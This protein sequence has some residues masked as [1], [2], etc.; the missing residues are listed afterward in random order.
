ME[1]SH[2]PTT[3]PYE[4]FISMEYELRKHLSEQVSNF[5]DVQQALIRNEDV[6]FLWSISPVVIGRT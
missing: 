2:K 5:D 3:A 4:L 6:Q 1:G